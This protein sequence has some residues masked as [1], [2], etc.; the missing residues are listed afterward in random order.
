MREN[1]ILMNKGD[2]KRKFFK[3]IIY[4]FQIYIIIYSKI[5]LIKKEED[6]KELMIQRVFARKKRARVQALTWDSFTNG[7]RK[8]GA[9][10][11]C[12]GHR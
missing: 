12:C 10:N 6:C 3:I 1:A 4:T 8:V 11:T 9:A 2:L 5:K 7:R